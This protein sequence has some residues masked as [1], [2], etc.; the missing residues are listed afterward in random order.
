MDLSPR[1]PGVCD[2]GSGEAGNDIGG[3]GGP[4]YGISL[5]TL[6]LETGGETPQTTTSDPTISARVK[7]Y[8]TGLPESLVKSGIG[9][10]DEDALQFPAALEDALCEASFSAC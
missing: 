9:L 10:E 7:G 8:D 5:S 2:S 6:G 4:M 1:F 3:R